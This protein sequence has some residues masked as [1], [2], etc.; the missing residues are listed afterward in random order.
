MTKVE[1]INVSGGASLTGVVV[2]AF[3]KIIIMF[4]NFGYKFGA[5]LYRGYT[6][7]YCK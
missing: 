6:N 1:L 2:N 7:H 4:Y 5:N 3:A